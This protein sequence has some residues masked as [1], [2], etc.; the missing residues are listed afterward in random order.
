VESTDCLPAKDDF[1]QSIS[2]S[3]YGRRERDG[4][5]AGVN[6]RHEKSQG[7]H[8]RFVMFVA[9]YLFQKKYY[10]DFDA[11]DGRDAAGT[12]F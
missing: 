9:R 7:N 6:A 2:R 12:G 4:S 11:L 5:R 1:P 10:C 8:C 3:T